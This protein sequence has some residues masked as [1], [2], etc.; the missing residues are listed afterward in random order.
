MECPG[1]DQDLREPAPSATAFIIIIIIINWP[2]AFSHRRLI[3][4]SEN[5]IRKNSGVIRKV[6]TA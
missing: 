2:N 1:R 6:N 3:V 5:V 4:N